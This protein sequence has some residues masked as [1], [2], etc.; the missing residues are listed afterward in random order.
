MKPSKLTESRND[1]SDALEW[2]RAQPTEFGQWAV[3]SEGVLFSSETSAA[4][5]ARMYGKDLVRVEGH[6]PGWLAQNPRRR[7]CQVK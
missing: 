4:T 5:F 2:L 1:V 6:E 7:Y 3:V